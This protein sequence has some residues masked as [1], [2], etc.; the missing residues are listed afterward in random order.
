MKPHRP[1]PHKTS[2]SPH[3]SPIVIVQ[4]AANRRRFLSFSSQLRIRFPLFLSFI[5]SASYDLA[6]QQPLP[7]R[8]VR[9]LTLAGQPVGDSINKFI[10]YTTQVSQVTLNLANYLTTIFE[11]YGQLIQMASLKLILITLKH[12]F[13]FCLVGPRSMN[14]G[15]SGVQVQLGHMEQFK[16]RTQVTLNLARLMALVHTA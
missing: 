10:T 15:R 14:L 5:L 2:R 9:I 16:E 13:D 8:Y 7:S 4:V 11:I 1:H 12:G 6:R 3:V